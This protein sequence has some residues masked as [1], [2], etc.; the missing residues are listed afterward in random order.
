MTTVTS[1]S[2]PN[3]GALRVGWVG[4]GDQG[5]PMARAITEAGFE[6][7]IWVRRDSSLAALEGLPYIRH[8][9]LADLGAVSDVVGLCLREDSDIEDVLT[10]GGLLDS[11]RPG[12]ILINHG[13][14]LPGYASSLADRAARA[15]V[16]VLDAPVSGG[17]PGAEAKRLTTIVGGPEQALD[18]VRPVLESF[19]ATIAHMGPTG[20][21]QTGKLINNA[22]LMMNQRNVQD[23]LVLARGLDLDLRALMSLLLAGTARSFALEALA[24]AVTTD[25][26]EH[27]RTLQVID[28]D[29]FTE[30]MTTLGQDVA[31]LDAYARSGA[32][33]LPM[34][35][36]LVTG[37][38][39]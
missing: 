25:N 27:L 34:A 23:I 31:E 35:A 20:T 26:A 12:T 17:R 36:R 8:A 3:D 21:G 22:L 16:V 7:H 39:A 2:T 33:G 13:T 15:G 10:T 5:A 30:A 1:G 6:L 19:S 4:L 37:D 14:G 38:M 24:G 9:T 32:Q 18:K 28:M 29:I 11:M